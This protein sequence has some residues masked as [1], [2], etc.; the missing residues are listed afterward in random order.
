MVHHERAA[1]AEAPDGSERILHVST[2]K[3]DVIDLPGQ[4]ESRHHQACLRAV[5]LLVHSVTAHLGPY[6]H[7]LTSD[8]I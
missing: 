2:D 4:T 5:V 7:W 8:I 1:T 3:V 6:P